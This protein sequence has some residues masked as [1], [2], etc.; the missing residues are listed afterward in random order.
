MIFD[1]IIGTFLKMLNAFLSL[2]PI[3]D[4][5]DMFTKVSDL[6]SLWAILA[7]VSCF[8]PVNTVMHIL[9][10]ILIIYTISVGWAF[11][12]WLIAKIPTIN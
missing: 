11:V 2:L 5:S 1:A 8:L 7:N 12:N 9:T 4:F 10:L 3:L 6:A